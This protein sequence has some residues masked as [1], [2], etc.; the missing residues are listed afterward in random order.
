MKRDMRL[1]TWNVRS[2]YMSGSLTA[3]ASRELARYKLD[4]EGVQ[5][6]KWDEGGMV[7]A[8]DYI[9]FY[10]KQNKTHQLET[11][12]FVHHRIVREFKRVE[13][14]S[15]RMLYTGSSKKTDRT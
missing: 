4:L 13:S 10:G 2:L 14:V 9:F 8:Q 15:G 12:F 6:V 3:A 5:E 7:R 11:G 1:G